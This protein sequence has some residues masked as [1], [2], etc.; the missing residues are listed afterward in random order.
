[1]EATINLTNYKAIQL[2]RLKQTVIIQSWIDE[3]TYL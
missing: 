3:N 1:M 2:Q